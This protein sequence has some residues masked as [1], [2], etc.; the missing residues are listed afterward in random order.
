VMG[1]VEEVGA[2]SCE[3]NCRTGMGTEL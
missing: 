2:R 3:G 1:T